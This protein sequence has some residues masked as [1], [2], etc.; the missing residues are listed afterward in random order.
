[1]HAPPTRTPQASHTRAHTTT[2]ATPRRHKAANHA[3]GNRGRQGVSA[4]NWQSQSSTNDSRH[5]QSQNLV[6]G[7]T[8][9]QQEK[10]LGGYQQK[11]SRSLSPSLSEEPPVS[12]TTSISKLLS[13]LPVLPVDMADADRERPDA[14]RDRL[15]TCMDT[16]TSVGRS[17]DFRRARLSLDRWMQ[18]DGWMD[19]WSALCWM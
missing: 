12:I 8:F 11:S 7:H 10:E 4:R 19:G 2:P 16:C 5:W 14:E 9:Y 13:A 3:A 15:D 1:M 17:C 6:L 18:M